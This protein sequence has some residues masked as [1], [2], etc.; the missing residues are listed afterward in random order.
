MPYHSS[1]IEIVRQ[2]GLFDSEWYVSE[3]RDVTISGIDPIEHYLWLGARLFRDPSPE[4]DTSYYLESNPDVARDGINPLL[5]YVMFGRAEGRLGR[6]VSKH[7]CVRPPV[8]PYD[9]WLDVNRPSDV[10]ER[11]LKGALAAA[12]SRLPRISLIMPVFRP[13]IEFLEEAVES[14]FNQI[15]EDWELCIHVDGDDNPLLHSWLKDLV[16]RTHRVRLSISDANGGISAATNAAATLATGEFIAFF[17][18]DDLLTKN[19]LAHIALAALE[20]PHADIL[21][22]DDDKIDVTG[23]RYAPQFKPDWA[24]VLL[25]SYMYMSHLFVV[26]RALFQGLGGFRRGFEGSQDYDFA[27]RAAEKA[28]AVVHVPEVLYHWRA[29]AGST[30]TS[31]EAK[32]HSFV[33]GLRAVKEACDRRGISATAA[34]PEWAVA[35]RVG[36]FSLCFPDNGPRITIVIPTRN[37]MDLLQPCIESI[38]RLTT[39]AN[40]DILIVD[41]ESDDPECLAYMASSGHRVLRLASPEGKFSFAYLMNRA[42]ESV[43][44]EYVLLLNNDTLIRR[45]SWLSQMVGYAQMPNVGA[46]GAKLYFPDETIQHAGI[47]HGLYGDL[48]GPAFRNAPAHDHGYLAYTMVAR[49]YSAVT[50]ACLLSKR[51]IFLSLGGMDDEN[52]PVAYNDVDFCYR[53]VQ[54]GYTCVYCPEAELTHYEGKSRGFGDNVLELANFRK[55]Y[56]N[57][58]DC[59]YSLH[60]TRED[61]RFGIRPSKYAA[62]V[63]T[64]APLCIAM[65]S[66]NLNHEGAPNSMFEL[67]VGL[68]TKGYVDPVVIAPGDG[69]LRAYYEK[70]GIPVEI[71][72]HPLRNGF[73]AAVYE[74]RAEQLAGMLRMSGTELVYANTADAFWALDAARRA[75]LPAVWN[76]RES[77]PWNTY[78]QNLPEFLQKAAYDSFYSAYRVVFVASST[79]DIWSPLAG[80]DN[81]M[82]IQNGLDLS[83][84][85]A[86]MG[87]LT[88]AAARRQLGLID[89]EVAL[90]LVGTVCERKNQRVLLSAI[91]QMP[92][93]LAA[94]V[95]V[96][97]VGDRDNPY[98]R[99]LHEDRVALPTDWKERVVIV[100]ETDQPYLYF[101]AADISVCTSLR[102]SYPRVVLEAMALGLPLV[103][104]PVFGI[105][106]QAHANVNALFFSPKDSRMLKD[107]IIQLIESE[108]LRKRFSDNSTTLFGG[109]MQYDDMIERYAMTMREAAL[110][111]RSRESKYARDLK[112]ETLADNFGTCNL[113]VL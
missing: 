1:D 48:A 79:R 54:A 36:I 76:I 80:R 52:F 39:Y 42:V 107:L 98:S 22:S 103:T 23:R 9:A 89:G 5:H 47:I 7:A 43:D 29:T 32:P 96:F 102:E 55:R 63:L 51:Q 57:F 17:D 14:V 13:P 45:G 95:R 93:A 112:V 37:R 8:D 41:N 61:E 81:F 92:V 30:A 16:Q 53:L 44:S 82:V 66:H 64:R 46:V 85:K 78:Y 49:E 110:S 24:P 97:I 6:P 86:R 108:V 70:A 26:R 10:E 72:D 25:L 111:C 101:C 59:Y 11:R 34:Q 3:Y 99:M 77:E 84:L 105:A 35:A 56:R 40:Y 100:P 2:S 90:V 68:K 15:Y 27:L 71:I 4:F 73:E 109:L 19:A 104:T 91:A 69:P 87:G 18:Q 94:N 58:K 12:G 33:A 21:Y 20:N 38:E 74:G 83:R 65:F 67:V 60:L 88:R 31:G 50:A 113:R 75:G 106:E 28:R 62:P